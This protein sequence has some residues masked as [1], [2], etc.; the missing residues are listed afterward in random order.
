LTQNWDCHGCSDCCRIEAVITDREKQDIE[1]LDVANDPEVAPKPW[2]P[3]VGR[4]EQRLGRPAD[5]AP[6][7]ELRAG[8]CTLAQHGELEKLVACYSR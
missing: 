3:P 8:Q 1:M 6:P 2:F 4:G 5:S 7:P